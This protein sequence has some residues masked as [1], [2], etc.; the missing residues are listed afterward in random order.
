MTEYVKIATGEVYTDAMIRAELKMVLPQDVLGD[1]VASSI[2][3]ELVSD[4]VPSFDARRFSL[5]SEI[6]LVG[7]VWTRTYSLSEI[8]S[9]FALAKAERFDA[10]RAV[11]VAKRDAGVTVDFGAGDVLI[12]TDPSAKADIESLADDLV[13]RAAAGEVAS[14]QNFATSYYEIVTGC[15]PAMAT[16]MRDAVA[17]HWRAVWANDAALGA[18]LNALNEVDFAS[19]SAALAA[20]DAIDLSSGWPE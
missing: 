16:T 5:S 17:A 15:T 13:R 14:T 18:M 4:D 9:W 6:V 12:R 3:Q 19:P 20:L 2:F 7:D 11:F 10:L 1:H 8:P